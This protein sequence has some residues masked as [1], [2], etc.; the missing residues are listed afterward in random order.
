[1]IKRRFGDR[2]DGFR[3]RKADPTNVIIP[4]IIKDREDA[5][6]FFDAEI[7][8]TKITDLIHKKR[9]EGLKIGI[10]DYVVAA[11]VRTLSQFPRINR[12]VAGRRIYA[13]KGLFVSLIIKKEMDFENH[14]TAV[15]ICFKPESTLLEINKKMHDLIAKSKG[16][17]S[18][19]GMDKL[20]HFLIHMPRLI[21][22]PA[23]RVLNWLDF[24]GIMPKFVHRV[25]PFHSSVLITNMGSVG[26]DAIYHSIGNWGTS[27]IFVAMGIKRKRVSIDNEGTAKSKRYLNIRI[28]ADERIA[29]GFYLSK[30]L[31]YFSQIFLK[32][33]LLE[34]PPALVLEDD[35]I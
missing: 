24:H 31:K 14:R 25:S 12:F 33:E 19:N 11:S 2:Y 26:G 32:P 35:Q 18:M 21:I 29:D 13:R 3:L 1:M 9:A 22:R 7:D 4:Y 30:S 34:T 10:F 23:I 17:D 8:I 27:S 28:V 15:K 6:V 16:H 5:Q 20:L